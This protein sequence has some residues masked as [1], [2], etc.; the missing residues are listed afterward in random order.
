MLMDELEA[1]YEL[2]EELPF[3]GEAV[4]H[5]RIKGLRR[6]LLGRSQYHLYYAVSE[7]EATVEVLSFWHTSRGP[8]P[9]V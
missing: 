1:A 9:L 2:I 7:D 5:G 4:P 8:R 6:V 3:A